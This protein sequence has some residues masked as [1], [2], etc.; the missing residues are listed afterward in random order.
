MK[1]LVTPSNISFAGSVVTLTGVNVQLSQ[2]L[3][4]ANATTGVIHYSISGPA[5]TAYTQA[6]N[7][8][9]TLATAPTAGD[10]LTVY[11]DDGIPNSATAS[12]TTTFT[13]VGASA[14]ILAAN[15]TRKSVILANSI[16]GSTYYILFGTGVASASNYS[17]VLE[18][19]DT[20]SI[21]GV[22]FAFQG[23]GA[24]AGNLNVTEIS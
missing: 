16:G 1:Q 2:I 14:Q 21:S 11:F 7:S 18:A 10:K 24:G 17:L 6:A 23:F 13:S 15:S 5:P 22:L 12:T 3:L 8:T 19:G 4:V 9:I 20:A